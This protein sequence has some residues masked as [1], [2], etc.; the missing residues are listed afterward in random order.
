MYIIQLVIYSTQLFFLKQ[1]FARL[2]L[3]R[4]DETRIKFNNK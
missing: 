4:S 3:I 2:V 1:M